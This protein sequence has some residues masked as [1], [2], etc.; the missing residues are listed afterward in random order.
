VG[1]EWWRLQY[2]ILWR[3]GEGEVKELEKGERRDRY[4]MEELSG[5]R[6]QL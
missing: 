1:K 5:S 6:K 4:K 3:E 2:L